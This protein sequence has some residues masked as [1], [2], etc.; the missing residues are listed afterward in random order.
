MTI[1][2]LHTIT[3]LLVAVDGTTSRQHLHRTEGNL[4]AELQ[5]IVG[6]AEVEALPLRECPNQPER[7]VDAWT[8]AGGDLRPNWVA[9]ALA[10]LVSGDHSRVLYGPVVVLTSDQGTGRCYDLPATLVDGIGTA[11]AHLG[12]ASTIAGKIEQALQD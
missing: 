2:P 9:T 5:N 8:A 12:Q 3:G 1:T 7:T 6:V 10:A 11:A 4:L